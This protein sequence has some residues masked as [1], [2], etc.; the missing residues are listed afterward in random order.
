MFSIFS[1]KR[2]RFKATLRELCKTCIIYKV[3]FNKNA[4]S[5]VKPVKELGCSGVMIRSQY[6]L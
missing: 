5:I 3:V 4:G 6:K 2:L 1:K